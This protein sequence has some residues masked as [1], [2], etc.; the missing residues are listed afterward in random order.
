MDGS[1]TSDW[2]YVS[3][4]RATAEPE[5]EGNHQLCPERYTFSNSAAAQAQAQED[6]RRIVNLLEF[7]AL[8][9]KT[10]IFTLDHEHHVRTRLSHSYEVA[11][12]GSILF[13][14]IME[15]RV[16]G[17]PVNARDMK[18]E[19]VSERLGDTDKQEFL[20]YSLMTACL[21]HDIGNPPFGHAGE[22]MI[23]EWFASHRGML[24]AAIATYG[25]DASRIAFARDFLP[26]LIEFEGNANSLRIALRESSLYD[27]KRPN[28]TAT[29]IAALV[30]YPWQA[31][32]SEGKGKGC[33]F[34]YFVSDVP[35]IKELY[36]DAAP[37]E[38]G[39]PRGRHPLSFIMEAA[40]DI[41]YTTSDFEDAVR[42]GDLIVGEALRFALSDECLA[43]L[44]FTWDDRRDRIA[45]SLLNLLAILA[46]TGDDVAYMQR[47]LAQLTAST[48]TIERT[49]SFC[50]YV[51]DSDGAYD[52]G[53]FRRNAADYLGSP[54]EP[55][56]TF[57]AALRQ[58]PGLIG[59]E[60]RQMQETYVARWVDIVRRWFCFSMTKSFVEHPDAFAYGTEA[61]SDETLFGDHW[62]LMKLIK[63]VMADMVY[64]SQGAS[65]RDLEG[66]AVISNL[67]DRF[68]PAAI[69]CADP[70]A[71]R[72][73]TEGNHEG[74]VALLR[75]I[76]LRHR[77]DYNDR[78]HAYRDA[79]DG[80]DW[81]QEQAVYERCMMVLDFITEMTD[82]RA[83]EM[84]ESIN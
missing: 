35:R 5:P 73:D 14:E 36:R 40:D 38:A 22:N 42:M 25:D 70:V 64:Q 31:A 55:Q 81:P 56:H 10:Q 39:V 17:K 47:R 30:K 49:D 19:R 15:R 76:P 16:D 80:K 33:K 53:A 82:G 32:E 9:D 71:L 8:K 72:F 51:G 45:F 24:E 4:H 27:G 83:V 68:I 26:D 43:D 44:G 67:L 66:S 69:V 23:R 48:G 18:A 20:R 41:S 46:G 61:I 21:L 65:L 57:R 3:S 62:R 12:T 6:Y 63:K 11:T 34:N 78:R 50:V 60:R 54:D 74:D 28:L 2:W 84:Y 1:F 77:L 58:N 37:F 7:R 75:A 52:F 13:S 79:N 29:T 59:H